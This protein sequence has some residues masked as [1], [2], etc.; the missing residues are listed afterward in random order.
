MEVDYH[1]I[2]EKVLRKDLS[3]GFVSGKDNLADAFTKPLPAPQFLFFRSKF[4]LSFEGMLKK[5][6]ALLLVSL[7]FNR[8]DEV[9]TNRFTNILD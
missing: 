8:S 3:V 2:R 1:F 4:P 7:C 6:K 5:L 9:N